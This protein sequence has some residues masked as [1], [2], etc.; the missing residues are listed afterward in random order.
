MKCFKTTA[1]MLLLVLGVAFLAIDRAEAQTFQRRIY[2]AKFLCGE[3]SNNAGLAIEGPV[4]RGN[5]QTVI[6]VHNPTFVPTFVLKRAVLMWDDDFPSPGPP[7]EVPMPPGTWRW[8][9]LPSRWAVRVDCQDIRLDLL[10]LPPGPPFQFIEGYVT[11][12]TFFNTNTL[13]V[14]GAYTSYGFR[15]VR[16]CDI[17]QAPCVVSS[18]CPIPGENCAAAQ[19]VTGHSTH[20]ERISFTEVP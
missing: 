4:K 12:E 17:S 10:G 15:D 13:D 9:N 16:R 20:T 2:T 19:D 14:V 1:A 5:Y 7:Y 8:F 18:D 6:N 3:K 11:L